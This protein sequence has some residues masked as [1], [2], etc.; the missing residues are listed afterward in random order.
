MAIA[1]FLAVI[2][3]FDTFST[4]AAIHRGFT[5]SLMFAVAIG[6]ITAFA[7]GWYFHMKFWRLVAMFS[8]AA[9]SHGLLDLFTTAGNGIEL[10]WP[11]SNARLG[12]WGPIPVA[13]LGFDWPDPRR[14]RA[15][16]FELLYIWLPVTFV[17]LVTFVW[18]QPRR[19]LNLP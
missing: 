17:V 19:K 10:F 11:I 8:A 7:T 5:H 6:L 18:R 13:D 2:P 14:S 1:A 12:P 9:A 4:S 15:L 3:D 16:A